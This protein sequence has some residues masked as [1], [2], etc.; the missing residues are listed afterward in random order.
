MNWSQFAVVADSAAGVG[1]LR[2]TAPDAPLFL[3]K[4]GSYCWPTKIWEDFCRLAAN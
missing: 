1:V 3:I 2:P 4:P